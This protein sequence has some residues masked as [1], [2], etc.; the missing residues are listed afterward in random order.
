MF[1]TTGN[2]GYSLMTSTVTFLDLPRV[3]KGV[4]KPSL[5]PVFFPPSFLWHFYNLSVIPYIEAHSDHYST[6]S[7]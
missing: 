3:S 7:F 2:T 6:K 1:S 4:L 5:I